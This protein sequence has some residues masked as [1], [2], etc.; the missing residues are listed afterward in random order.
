MI[1]NEN[2]SAN[3][4]SSSLLHFRTSTLQHLL[5]LSV[6]VSA[7]GFFV[8]VY[9]LL[10]FS[11]IRKSSLAAIGLNENAILEKGEIL[12][13]IQMIGMLM[14]GI[15][16]GILGDKKGR[17]KV[18]FGSIVL[19]SIAN[20]LNG[21]VQNLDQY[22]MLRFLAG[23]GLAGELGA[24]VTL[25]S[26]QL[27]K[28][29]RGLA[30]GFIAGFGVLGAVFAYFIS[31][32][33]DWRICYFIGGVM[34]L[35]LLVLRIQV[36]ESGMFKEIKQTNVSRGNFLMFFT[37]KNRFLKF[38]LCIFIGLPVWYIIGILVTF[39]DQFG[40]YFGVDNIQPG[41][42]VLYLYLAVAAGDFAVG[43]L[44]EVLKSRKKTLYIFFGICIVFLILFFTQQNMSSAYFY[45][46]IAGLGFG[47]GLN[48][49][50]LTTSI[51]QFGTNLRATATISISN[52]V[53]GALPLL[54]LLFKTLRSWTG[55]YVRGALITGII[56]LAIAIVSSLFLKETYGK[57]L[58][59]VET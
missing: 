21:L 47:A 11:I 14:G 10:L 17:L 20:I 13:S 12:I 7:L 39:S 28:D 5:Q 45:F 6:I 37:N 43:W 35:L 53:R 22:I 30:A 4:V 9:D 19:Y 56:I 18:L 8:D 51:E 40:K 57:D 16:F 48:V 52:F 54:I 2:N 3:H 15:L 58:D 49:I 38:I 25:V 24:G 1:K 55:D 36:S 44:C 33:F 41:K 42:S 50:Y 27:P 23:L 31:Q 29:K 34:G 26:E 59:F 46:I 32:F